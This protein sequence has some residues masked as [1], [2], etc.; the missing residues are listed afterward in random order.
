M[1]DTQVAIVGCGLA[2][3]N[4][5]RLLHRAGVDFRLL[6][7]RDRAGGRIMTVDEAGR[8]TNDGFDLGPS[9]FWPEMQPAIGELVAELALPAFAQFNEGDMAFERNVRERALRVPGFQ[10]EPQ[11]MRLVGGS[12][13]LVRAL[14]NDLPDDRLQ[15]RARVTAMR[16]SERCVELTV[17][18]AEGRRV[19]IKAEQ[20]IAALPPRLLE[21]TFKFEPALD[22]QTIRLWRETPT[23]MAPHAKVVAIYDRRFWRDAGMSGMAQS[24][25][26]P[27]GEIHDATTSSG[28]AALFGFVGIPARQRVS[29]DQAA[30][31]SACVEQFTRIFGQDAA[32]PRATLY[33]D[34]ASDPLSATPLDLIA[35]GH[36]RDGIDSW[37]GGAWQARL[38]LAG[39]ESSAVHAGYLAGA[40]YA[41]WLAVARLTSGVPAS[42]ST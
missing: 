42:T 37:V 7:A 40:I 25:V 33:K 20:V 5:A 27:M 19:T 9:W 39:S 35:V 18:H 23:W 30:I 22:S 3:L 12:A 21:A 15:F 24:L 4:A 36:P 41:S 29:L 16:L 32:N 2:G 28:R 6:E 10:Q 1:A 13:A 31:V 34:W 14:S 26:G 17:E 38:S 8:L 11:S